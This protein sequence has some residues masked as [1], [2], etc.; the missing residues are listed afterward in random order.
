MATTN[1][2]TGDRL[3][4]TPKTSPEAKPHKGL[5]YTYNDIK[6][7]VYQCS[8]CFIKVSTSNGKCPLCGNQL[9]K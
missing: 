6:F 7:D 5:P 4:N 9:A 3:V 1:D 8:N 2:I